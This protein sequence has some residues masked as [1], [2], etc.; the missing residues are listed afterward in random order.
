MSKFDRRKPQQPQVVVN[1]K[2]RY[3]EVRVSSDSEDLGVMNTRDA[4]QH[5][6][7]QG[8]DL[9]LITEKASPPVCK[10]VDLNK[11]LY[12]QKQRA[13]EAAKKQREG[14]IEIKE[15]QFRPNIDN[16]DFE[17]KCKHVQ[18]FVEK[19]NHVK[20]MVRFRGR[21]MANTKVGFEIINRL[22]DEVS[23]LT[24]EA[25]PNLN[26]NRLIAVVKGEK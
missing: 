24:F 14:R 9:V 3:S 15:V 6:K 7:G 20:L 13:K 18:R 1:E 16:H 25:R 2:I 8:L 5:A 21:E 26:G 23:G 12:Q 10:I 19:G 17:T 4:V 11:F 22:M